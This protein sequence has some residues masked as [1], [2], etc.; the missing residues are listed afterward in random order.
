[1][2]TEWLVQLC[3][4]S[5]CVTAESCEERLQ[6]GERGRR[7]CSRTC[8]SDAECGSKR[9]C[10]CDGQCGFS[11]VAP[12]NWIHHALQCKTLHACT[13][14]SAEE[15]CAWKET[16]D[17]SFFCTQNKHND[18]EHY[19]LFIIFKKFYDF[20]MFIYSM[21]SGYVPSKNLLSILWTNLE[22]SDT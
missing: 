10:L 12:G 1:M 15:V 16:W 20:K 3:M 17:G 21:P 6:A 2:K 7:T 14:A 4:I 11:C 8:K 18:A 5:V 13:S 19:F 22:E 9:Q